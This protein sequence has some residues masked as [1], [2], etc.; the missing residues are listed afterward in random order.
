MF[1]LRKNRKF[2]YLDTWL[3][4]NI[5]TNI[6]MYICMYNVH[7]NILIVYEG[8]LELSKMKLEN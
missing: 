8:W 7:T 5:H 1:S 3:H 4:T 2:L 6:H